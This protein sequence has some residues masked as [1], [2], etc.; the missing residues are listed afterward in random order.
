MCP[1][2]RRRAAR[3][4]VRS[5]V[6]GLVL[7][8]L[9]GALS[10]TQARHRAPA[11]SSE[12]RALWVTRTTLTTPASVTAMVKAAQAGRFNTL[13]VQVRG[14][15]DAYFSGG[16][17]PLAAQLANQPDSF[18]PLA[19][20]IA[21]AHA[22]GI[23]VHAW[24]NIGLVASA[25]DLPV[26]HAHIVFRHP[27]WL[28]VPRELARDMALLD[29]RS[30]LYLDK[31]MRWTRSQSAEVEGLY[32]SPVQED[33]ASATVAVVGD[34]VSRYAVD[35]VH[36]DYV[37]YPT[38][39][40][41]YSRR[42]LEAFR[43]DMLARLDDTD[44][45]QQERAL[46]PDL[47]AWT[48]AFPAEWQR[49]RRDRLTGLVSRIRECVRTRRPQALV[50]AAVMP[51]ASEASSHRLQDWSAWLD[52]RLLDVVCPMAYSTDTSGFTAQMT[53]ARQAAGSKPVWAGIGSYRLSPAQ[54]IEDI[55]IARR[56][57]ASGIVLFSYDSVA[58]SQ[59]YLAQVARAA[60]AP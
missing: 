12:V 60:F 45:R 27:E 3:D 8:A 32:A 16:L 28:M 39:D 26:S 42:S 17:E 14:R 40:F 11:V 7:L 21:L 59:Q 50:S 56:L 1:D 37:R 35:G 51:D 44:R 5:L 13:L 30:Q 54:T 6:A 31:L 41:D 19:L 53:R 24:I 36:L 58:G 18:D 25:V 57:G 2:R 9:T 34:L 48:E 33:A 15:G 20:T 47:V 10:A 52:H 38:E 46:G 55:R 22:R 23:R 49:F 43:A 4:L 29:P